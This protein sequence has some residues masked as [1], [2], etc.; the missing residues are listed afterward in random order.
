[1]YVCLPLRSSYDRA[2]SVLDIC[3]AGGVPVFL[4]ADFLP[5]QTESDDLWRMES[6][7][8]VELQ[9]APQEEVL[10]A[11][12]AQRDDSATPVLTALSAAFSGLVSM[13]PAFP[14]QQGGGH[15]RPPFS[16]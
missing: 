6:Q 11:P 8:V 7:D 9:E 12:Q 4:M 1:V 14:R 15:L 13:K 3:E 10:P 16:L 5:L 2:Q